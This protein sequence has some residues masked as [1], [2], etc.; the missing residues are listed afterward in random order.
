MSAAE[1][2][3]DPF[4][5]DWRVVRPNTDDAYTVAVLQARTE[6]YAIDIEVNDNPRFGRRL[7]ISGRDTITREGD[8]SNERED[9][10]WFAETF[11]RDQWRA[12]VHD[13]GREWNTA[14]YRASASAAAPTESLDI[15]NLQ[16]DTVP[17]EEDPNDVFAQLP[18]TDPDPDYEDRF[19]ETA[20]VG[21]YL[22]ENDVFQNFAEDE[23]GISFRVVDTE[24]NASYAAS[25]LA[26]D[27]WLAE[28][29]G[30]DQWQAYVAS[31]AK[32]W[33]TGTYSSGWFND[34]TWK[35]GYF[36]PIDQPKDMRFVTVNLSDFTE[37]PLVSEEP[38]VELYRA[39]LG[40]L[41][42]GED[43]FNNV[44]GEL[45]LEVEDRQVQMQLTVLDDGQQRSQIAV[46]R[47]DALT[48]EQ[49]A[50]VDT[51]LGQGATERLFRDAKDFLV[52]NFDRP[53]QELLASMDEQVQA[54]DAQIGRDEDYFF[55]G[56][57]EL[58][59]KLGVRGEQ[60]RY[61]EGNLAA[62]RALEL[63]AEGFEY[64]A[65]W[66]NLAATHEHLFQDCY[67]WAGQ[68]RDVELSVP[69]PF[70]PS[71]RTDFCPVEELP[72]WIGAVEELEAKLFTT[73]DFHG[74]VQ[75]L[76][77]MH[78]T[79]NYIHP[80][81]DGN[82]RT[83]RAFM[84]QEATAAGVYLDWSQ[85]SE[86]VLNYASVASMAARNGVDQI[87]YMTMYFELAEALDYEPHDAG[88]S[89]IPELQTDR[90]TPIPWT[91]VEGVQLPSQAVS[92]VVDDYEDW[93]EDSE[94]LAIDF[95]EDDQL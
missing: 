79:L 35:E 43:T 22:L 89:L 62:Q 57:T 4:S 88:W 90:E 60:W 20:R 94:D 81:R 13:L 92:N 49:R 59:N 53:W 86:E 68:A 6:R 48:E 40:D 36:A 8:Q 24:T 77:Q 29:F 11:G 50:E 80:F 69:N 51:F 75:L 54:S 72:A 91:P 93:D 39:E 7:L 5:L 85:A 73:E 74:R 83:I 46:T 71:G 34:K 19:R 1:T 10:P 47:P 2:P 58:K 45:R 42:N 61:I 56:T 63:P 32:H 38:R 41:V 66:D 23:L 82:D 27:Q 21:K 44:T 55:D 95:E 18:T 16:W 76:A 9:N 52:D 30:R 12:F 87:P 28:T 37:Q 65:A 31:R 84:E 33:E 17:I 70:A 15:M 14:A 78:T 26:G 3:I 25:E 67:D 64:E